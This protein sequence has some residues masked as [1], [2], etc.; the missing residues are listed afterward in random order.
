MPEGRSPNAKNFLPTRSPHA[1]WEHLRLL[2]L[3][4]LEEE[5]WSSRERSPR[6]NDIFTWQ[7][8]S[9]RQ[10]LK[11]C[12]KKCQKKM[13]KNYLCWRWPPSETERSKKEINCWWLLFLCGTDLLWRERSPKKTATKKEEHMVR[14]LYIHEMREKCFRER[15]R[16]REC[17]WL[18]LF[19]CLFVC[20]FEEI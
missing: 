12:Q 7:G 11:K 18:C 5:W 6:K 2:L 13:S 17:V 19:V 8:Q 20:L 1:R 9:G 14:D 15:E 3:W 10:C 16:E 4:L